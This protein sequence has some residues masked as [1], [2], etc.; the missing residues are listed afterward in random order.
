[1]RVLI[2][3]AAGFIGRSLVSRL[4]SNVALPGLG[5]SGRELVL[6]DRLLEPSLGGPGTVLIEGDFRDPSV[7]DQ[8]LSGPVD[9]LYHLASTPGGTAESD[10]PL[11]LSVNLSGTLAVLEALRNSGSRPRFVF[12]SSI[13]VYG[14]P[15][16]PQIDEQT[17]AE[18]SFSYGAQK[19][20]CEFLLRDYS[21]R[22][23]VEGVSLR[24]PGIVARP[25]AD[26]MISI[27]M[28]DLIRELSA[29]RPFT[30]PVGP[31]GVAWFMSRE[32]VV[33][34]LLHAASLP[35]EVCSQRRAWLLPVLRA[36]M[37]QV[38]QAI[39]ELRNTNVSRLLTYEPNPTVQA[40]FANYPPLQCPASIDV[41]FC[42]DGSLSRLVQRALVE[43]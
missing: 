36:T 38:A 20:I 12:A 9:C 8:A 19:L 23:L 1:M 40:Q 15:M 11:G 13:G 5:D 16:P 7:L 3:G 30:C 41:G 21:R 25:R 17:A 43:V 14:A 10:L 33:D 18:P 4:R 2:T 32:C 22:G 35:R 6:V 34:N 24:L 29:G 42:H 37:A 39:L 28:S 31:E 26:G 27:F